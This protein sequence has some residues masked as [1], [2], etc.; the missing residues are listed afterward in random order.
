MISRTSPTAY[1]GKHPF[2]RDSRKGNVLRLSLLILGILVSYCALASQARADIRFVQQ[3]AAIPQSP[4]QTVMVN[5][6]NPQTTGNLNIVV[7]GWNDATATVTSVTDSLGNSYQLAV[8]PTTDGGGN[9]TQSIYYAANI[10]SA[11]AGANTVTVTFSR[12]AIYPDIRIIEFSGVGTLSPV[13]VTAGAGGNSATSSSGP[14][15]TTNGYD[16][17]FGANMVVTW[18]FNPGTGFTNIVITDDGDIAEYEIASSAGSYNATAPLGA[19]P[20]V[21]QMVAFKGA[22]TGPYLTGQWTTQ[23]TLAPINPIHAALLN[24][25]TILLVAGSGNCPASQGPPCPSGPPYSAYVYD[26]VAG[27]L[28]QNTQITWDMF[29]NG[30][31]LLA[32]GQVLFAGGTLQYDPFYGA[33]NAA[34][35]DPSQPVASAFTNVASMANGRWYPTLTTLPNG[36]VIAM[37]GLGTNGSLTNAIETYNPGSNTWSSAGTGPGVLYPRFHV[38]PNGQLFY[39]GPSQDTYFFNPSGNTWTYL[40]NTNYQNQRGYGTSVLLPLSP[41]NG[42]DPKVM[43]MGGDNPA[44]NTTEIVDLNNPGAGWQWGPLMSQPRIEMNAVILPT[45]KI[46]ALGGATYDEDTT[47]ASLNADLYD[48]ASKTFSSAGANTYPRLYHSVALLL[49]DATVWLAGG[50]PTRGVYEQHMEIYKPAYLFTPSGGLAAR[51]SIGS[52]TP[53]S[54]A[55]GSQFTLQTSSQAS[56][57]SVVLVRTGAVTHAFHADQ[58]LVGMNFTRVTGG[59]K[60]TAPPNSNIAPPGYYMM[61]IVNRSGVPS[62][63]LIVQLHS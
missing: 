61:F 26:P 55:Y 3:N 27:T 13:D 59:L 7:V 35:F 4:Q 12:A 42:Y 17:I 54:I 43:I 5:F 51:P 62:K 19:G 52:G 44:T 23:S 11:G 18:T 63:A 47:H 50:N 6:T 38:L 32:N 60:V 1:C 34:I 49:P 48:P 53:T 28:T 21:M 45:G 46:L 24:N 56:I 25:G 37:S 20:W 57:A 41:A 33:Q 22:A 9:L 58:R 14:A 16:L 8:G 10:G 39:S 40:G 31:S 36:Q 15:T 2:S 30:A 29:C